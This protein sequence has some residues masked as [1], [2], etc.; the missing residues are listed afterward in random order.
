[1]I[2]VEPEDE[3][4]NFD[5]DVRVP[6]QKFLSE[7]PFGSKVNFKNREYWRK[8][9]PQLHDLYGGVCSYTAHRITLD[10]GFST[11]EHFLSRNNY[12]ELAFEWWNYRLVCGR[13]NGC[14]SDYEDVADPFVISDGMFEIWF[15]ALI[16][17]PG[18]A[19][20]GEQLA[21]ATSTIRRLKLNDYP[22]F[23]ARMEHARSFCDGVPINRLRKEAP[24]LARELER[25]GLDDPEML[26]EV[27][28]W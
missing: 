5:A 2:P 26:A 24:F 8:I 9:I 13:L 17:R 19:A 21:L 16:V 23:D 15:P 18:V 7:I 14:K 1:M 27:M 11:V 6:G 12:P 20:E 10:T 3:P 25:Q 28:G 4:D 22:V